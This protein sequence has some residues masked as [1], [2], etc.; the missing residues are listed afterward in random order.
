[1]SRERS[2]AVGAASDTGRLRDH[3]EDSYLVRPPVFAVA[4][5]MG[6]HAAGEVASRLALESLEAAPLASDSGPKAIRRALGEANRVI[7][8]QSSGEGPSRG[9]GT[10]CVLLVLTDGAAHVGH[11]GDSRFYLLRSDSLTQLTRDHTVVADMVDKGLMTDEQ[12]MT[13]SSRGYLTRALGGAAAVEPDVQTVPIQPKD[14]FLLCSDGLTTMV[15]DEEIRLILT[16]EADPQRAAEALVAAANEAGG[17]DNITALVVDPASD[18]AAGVKPR[19]RRAIGWVQAAIVILALLAGML[20]LLYFGGLL[21]GAPTA[22]AT[23]PPAVERPPTSPQAPSGTVAPVPTTQPVPTGGAEP[24]TG[25]RPAPD[26]T[27]IR[28]SPGPTSLP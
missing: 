14:R 27:A 10:T 5:G 21:G 26:S 23:S 2:A 19:G 28:L 20:A 16:R 6:G 4:D 15:A 11:V 13:D 18:V 7:F 8:E 22:P 25:T 1:M 17:E 24:T 12:A 3:N 9:M